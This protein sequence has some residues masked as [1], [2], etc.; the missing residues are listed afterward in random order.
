MLS[1]NIVDFNKESV[2]E[3]NNHYSIPDVIIESNEWNIVYEDEPD[4]IREIEDRGFR[5]YFTNN[6]YYSEKIELTI[7]NTKY[8]KIM[9]LNKTCSE[10][11]LCCS[12]CQI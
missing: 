4:E 9:E 12:D 5:N 7:I 6:Y 11:H 2:V 3:E 1:D 10:V 8:K